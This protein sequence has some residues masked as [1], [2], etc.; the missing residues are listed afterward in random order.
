MTAGRASRAGTGKR[1]LGSS[2]IALVLAPAE[3]RP[4]AAPPNYVE[5]R[6]ARSEDGVYRF[7]EYSR[8]L[9]GGA[10]VDTFYIGVPGQNELYAGAGYPLKPTPT[11]TVTPLVYGVVGKENG[12][13]G[14]ALGASVLGTAGQ[15][16]VYAFLGYFEPLAGTV[17]RY[18]FLDSLDV[19]W[20][21]GRWELGASTGAFHAA[22][23]DWSW[24][25]GPVIVRND[26]RG[27]WRALLRGGSTVE[28]RLVRTLAF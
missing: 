22:A 20:K 4:Q 19:S 21:L 12:E 6:A 2:I 3:A 1:V 10:V 14:V 27:A 26:T 7:A 24:L 23:G 13:R 28:I 11:L 15:W 8:F 5:L 17:P 18:L 16:S 9:P 25:A